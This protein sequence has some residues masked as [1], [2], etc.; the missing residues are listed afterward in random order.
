MLDKPIVILGSITLLVEQVL[1][2]LHIVI[3]I[4]P[5]VEGLLKE[6]LKMEF[7][8]IKLSYV[9]FLCAL[10]KMGDQGDKFLVLRVFL[11]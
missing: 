10:F 9:V 7:L 8:P 2:I 3:V 11:E 6:L 5:I 4:D 1:A